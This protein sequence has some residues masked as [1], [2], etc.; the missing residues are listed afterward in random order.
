MPR[1][2]RE[3]SRGGCHTRQSD[4][5]LI[6]LQRWEKAVKRQGKNCRKSEKTKGADRKN[7]KTGEVPFKLDKYIISRPF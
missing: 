5:P 7:K 3:K 2:S 4:L 1:P 6:I